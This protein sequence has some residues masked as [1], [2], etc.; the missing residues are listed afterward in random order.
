MKPTGSL[1]DA[2]TE[3]L[4]VETDSELSPLEF[5]KLR[6]TCGVR[7]SRSSQSRKPQLPA[8]QNVTELR[9]SGTDGSEVFQ[10]C[11]CF[12]CP[13][14]QLL[15][16]H[17]KA[18]TRLAC[19]Q[20]AQ[21]ILRSMWATSL[22]TDRRRCL[23]IK[24]DARGRT[25]RCIDTQHPAEGI[26]PQIQMP[27]MLVRRKML[28]KRSSAVPRAHSTTHSVTHSMTHSVPQCNRSQQSPEKPGTNP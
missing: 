10:G 22:Q 21:Q 20:R 27:G 24:Q 23:P 11:T 6:G 16:V 7:K 1:A 12:P 26:V 14:T 3:S 8:E 28:W 18:E 15:A 5:C 17:R 19:G 25:P 9:D 2:A 4:I 13:G